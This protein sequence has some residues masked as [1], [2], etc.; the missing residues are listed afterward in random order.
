MNNVEPESRAKNTSKIFDYNAPISSAHLLQYRLNEERLALR[1]RQSAL[2]KESISLYLKMG[3]PN[4]C[5]LRKWRGKEHKHSHTN[6]L[7]RYFSVGDEIQKVQNRLIE[8]NK[9]ID[10]STPITKDGMFV[11]TAKQILSPEMFQKIFNYSSYRYQ[12]LI[13][14]LPAKLPEK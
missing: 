13:D 4:K 6:T 8:V 7:F 11:E 9:E 2:S 1:Q 12:E 3:S 14:S 10:K 5:N